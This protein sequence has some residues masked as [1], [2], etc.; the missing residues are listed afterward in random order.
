LYL[1]PLLTLI[2]MVIIPILFIS[3][4]WITKRTGPLYKI[5][6]SD[7]GEVN[8]YVEEIVSGQQVVKTYS[9]EDR[10]MEE[11]KEKSSTLQRS[12]FW[13]NTISGYIPKVMNTLNYFSFYHIALVSVIFILYG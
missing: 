3:M 4:R 12:G 9:P 8:G 7:L 10:V 5:Q 1:S 2:T 11:F 6:Q 13:A